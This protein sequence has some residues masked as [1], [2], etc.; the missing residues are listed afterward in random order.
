[1]RNILEINEL[2]KTY[3]NGILALSN[4]SLNVKEGEILALLG[5]NGAGKTTL[6]ST[7]C[8][9]SV[10]TSGQMIF[11]T[12]INNIM[13]LEPTHYHCHNNKFNNTK[14]PLVTLF[15]HFLL[16]VL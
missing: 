13:S 12:N 8:G 2:S 3:E 5:P 7:I 6:I 10:P 1:M 9:I 14:S 16:M 15:V 4:T 11:P